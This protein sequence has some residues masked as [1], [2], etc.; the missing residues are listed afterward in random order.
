MYHGAP[1]LS[2]LVNLNCS[3]VLY[4][5]KASDCAGEASSSAPKEWLAEAER[6]PPKLVAA[7]G[8]GRQGAF[9]V[10]RSSLVPELVTEVAL[11]GEDPSPSLRGMVLSPQHNAART[12]VALPLLRDWS[13]IPIEV[14]LRL[15]LHLSD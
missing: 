14:V 6:G 3:Q 11:A 7:T 8:S 2:H 12:R 9:T 5:P 10:L 13:F 4:R 1:W 15:S